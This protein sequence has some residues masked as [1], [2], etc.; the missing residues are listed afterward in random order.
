MYDDFQMPS[1]SQIEMMKQAYASEEEQEKPCVLPIF[2]SHHLSKLGQ[3]LFVQSRIVGKI[4]TLSSHT[5]TRQIGRQILTILSE[6]SIRIAQNTITTIPGADIQ[7][8]DVSTKILFGNL[9]E[10]IS[11]SLSLLCKMLDMSNSEILRDILLRQLTI[12]TLC[13][14]LYL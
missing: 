8:D 10:S 9:F 13:Q 2:L 4:R 6:N 1:D 5:R 7:I 14:M 3:M 11:D 12:S